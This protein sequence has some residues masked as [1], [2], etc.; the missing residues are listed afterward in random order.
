[1]KT[2]EFSI[3]LATTHDNDELGEIV[4]D[5]VRNGRSSYSESQLAA[6]VPE[7]KSGSDWNNRLLSQTIFV[8]ENSDS[9]LGFMSLAHGDYIDLAF[10]RPDARGVGMF[11][12]LY[13]EIESIACRNNVQ[14]LWVHSSLTAR[15]AFLAVGF[16]VSNEETLDLGGIQLNRFVMEKSIVVSDAG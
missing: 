8:A 2:R 7:P 16:R 10:I 12:M 4:F 13:N 15:P 1:M 5:A 9:L 6:W 11:R 3:R 14:R